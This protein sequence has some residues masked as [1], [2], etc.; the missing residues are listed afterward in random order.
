MRNSSLPSDTKDRVNP[1]GVF[2]VKSP[3]SKFG[4]TAT[5][6]VVVVVVDAELTLTSSRAN[7]D[8]EYELAAFSGPS[9]QSIVRVSQYNSMVL[10][11]KLA[12]G[13]FRA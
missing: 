13:T 1:S 5:V 10:T 8:T 2:G 12:R 4:T 3:N 11:R 9:G 7:I 6:K